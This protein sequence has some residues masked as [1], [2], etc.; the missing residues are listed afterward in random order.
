MKPNR[1][2]VYNSIS[3]MTILLTLQVVPFLMTSLLPCITVIPEDDL[4]KTHR[5]ITA[6]SNDRKMT[7][8]FQKSGFY[9]INKILL[10]QIK[11]TFCNS[12]CLIRVSSKCELDF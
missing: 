10:Y 9:G 5:I 8:T 11:Q 1:F 7:L 2:S 6:T 3:S 4:F 12:F